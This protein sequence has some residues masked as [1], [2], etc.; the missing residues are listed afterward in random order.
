MRPADREADA[1]GKAALRLERDMEAVYEGAKVIGYK[2]MRFV[3]TLRVH[4][5]L[6]TAHRLLSGSEISCGY[7]ELYLLR[8]ERA[9][10]DRW[11][12]SLWPEG[13]LVAARGLGRGLSSRRGPC[14]QG[15]GPC[16]R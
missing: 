9:R 13:R 10:W 16:R 1:D 14:P 6:E 5:G 12:R 2:A 7:T 4:G 3:M 8:G 11:S 15:S